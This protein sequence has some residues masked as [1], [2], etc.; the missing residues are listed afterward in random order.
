MK[1][2]PH[3]LSITVLL[4]SL[5]PGLVRAQAYVRTL[6]VSPTPGNPVASGTS[7]LAAAA[8]ITGASVSDRYLIKIEPGLYDLQSQ[9][10]TMQ[11]WVDIEGSGKVTTTLVG[12]GMT[13][14]EWLAS[15]DFDRPIVSGSDN[16]ELRDLRIRAK[17]DS[18]HIFPIGMFNR[19]ASPRVSNVKI[20]T[21]G[22]ESCWGIRNLGSDAK[23]SDVEIWAQCSQV[24]TAVASLTVV[25]PR[26]DSKIRLQRARLVIT[27][28]GTGL[29][30]DGNSIP[31]LLEDVEM[32]GGGVRLLDQARA[33][34]PPPQLVLRRVRIDGEATAIGT[35]RLALDSLLAT[36]SEVLATGT[37]IADFKTLT[38]RN[39]RVKAPVA[40][41]NALGGGVFASQI[42]G[43]FDSTNSNVQCAGVTDEAFAFYP[44]T[45][46]D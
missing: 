10:L 35:D 2:R 16:A 29:T 6:V 34:D 41:A 18:T 40:A 43:L 36:D 25:F 44:S 39:T 22:G 17:G 28:P 31:G 5:A 15:G 38:L 33:V 30:I 14:A 19:L 46:P 20:D 8:S 32:V 45:C 3:L 23:I 42:E 9:T 24:N 1:V 4:I 13:Q 37:G 21:D 12:L 7:L 26:V 11:P 27:G